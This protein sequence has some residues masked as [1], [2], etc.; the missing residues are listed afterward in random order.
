MLWQRITES[1]PS[2]SL[3]Q[4]REES[5][6][7]L[8]AFFN[9]IKI[10]PS[11]QNFP[12]DKW[13][14]LWFLKANN[15]LINIPVCFLVLFN[16]GGVWKY[17]KDFESFLAWPLILHQVSFSFLLESSKLVLCLQQYFFCACCDLAYIFW[18]QALQT[19]RPGNML[20]EM[21]IC[22]MLIYS[23]MRSLCS[24]MNRLWICVPKGTNLCPC[25]VPKHEKAELQDSI[26]FLPFP[27]KAVSC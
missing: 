1:V 5:M 20:K 19:S 15:F 8:K 22:Y 21:S 11:S 23:E 16:M 13:S 26:N 4:N 24:M 17:R 3:P 14:Y 12:G 2:T 27:I 18:K 9:L 7:H 10:F 25:F 6:F